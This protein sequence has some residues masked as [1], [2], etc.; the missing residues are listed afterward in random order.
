[1]N[2]P[3]WQTYFSPSK[4]WFFHVLLASRIFYCNSRLYQC[5]IPQ[6]V[7][8]LFLIAQKKRPDALNATQKNP[9]S[10][11]IMISEKK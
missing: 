8:K 4:R 10:L 5:P 3:P 11:K 2:P 9:S 1:M 6:T 7:Q